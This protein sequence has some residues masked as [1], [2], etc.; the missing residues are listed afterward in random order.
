ML[1]TCVWTTFISV[2]FPI[3][4]S[5]KP[6][7]A[8]WERR[9]SVIAILGT[10]CL[11]HWTLLYRTMFIVVSEWEPAVKACVVVQTNPSLLNTTF[12]FSMSSFL[13]VMSLSKKII[14]Y[15][16]P[17]VLISL[18]LFS[19][20][21]L[22]LLVILLERTC[23]NCSSRMVLC[24]SLCRFQQIAFLQYAT[25][26]SLRRQTT[27]FDWQVLNVLNLNS[28]CISLEPSSSSLIR[29]ITPRQHR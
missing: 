15:I 10:L 19:P 20:Q 7:I 16:Q 2:V 25:I 24:I 27:Q 14:Y 21:L 3:S 23:G 18:F 8:L 5:S 28:K 13:T 22:S 9:R 29:I 12:F 11:A 1:R 6:R 17:W 26:L 4:F